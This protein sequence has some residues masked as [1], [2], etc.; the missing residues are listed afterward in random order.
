MAH[1][2][3]AL[4]IFAEDPGVTLALVSISDSSQPAVAL[5]V[6]DPSFSSGL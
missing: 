2:L 1:Y 4:V 5:I 6:G 3:R